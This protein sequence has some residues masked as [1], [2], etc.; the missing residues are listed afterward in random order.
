VTLKQDIERLRAAL[1][2]IEAGY[3]QRLSAA[4]LASIARQAL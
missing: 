4:E 3:S 1:E 2:R